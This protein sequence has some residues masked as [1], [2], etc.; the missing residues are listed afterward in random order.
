M[1]VVFMGTPDFA[2]ATLEAIYNSSYEIV[3]VVTSPDKPAG[4]GLKMQCSEVKKYAIEKEIPILQPVKLKDPEFIE[5]LKK[6]NADVFVV[7]AFRMLPYEVYTIPPLGTFNVHASL[8]PQYRGAA[9]I[10]WAIMNGETKTGITTFF[11]NNQID[12]GDIILQRKTD[13]LPDEITGELY[14]RLKIL[15][16]EAALET[17]S[18]IEKGNIALLPQLSKIDEPLVPA[19]K[20]HKED[21]VIDWNLP[22]KDIIN[23]IRGLSPYPGAITFLTKSDGK[24]ASLKIFEAAITLEKSEEIAGKIDSD[25]RTFFYISSKDFKISVH[26]LQMEG[27]NRLNLTSF[28]QGSKVSNYTICV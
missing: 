28:L 7:V 9:P 8:L 21:T 24:T 19:P 1:R 5:A 11:L 17:L 25:D 6:W 3:G 10:H 22:A 26:N 12:C 20:I 15:G 27:K 2:V 4:R 13:I 23:K 14:D 18:L 16:A